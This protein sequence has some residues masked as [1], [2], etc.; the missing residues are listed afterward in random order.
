[1]PCPTDDPPPMAPPIGAGGE[2]VGTAGGQQCQNNQQQPNDDG[3]TFGGLHCEMKAPNG[4]AVT[5]QSLVSH[6]ADFSAP[7]SSA[8]AFP[9]LPPPPPP[10]HPFA[11][12]PSSSSSS[13]HQLHHLHHHHPYLPPIEFGPADCAYG[14]FGQLR[15]APLFLPAYNACSPAAFPSFSTT[16]SHHFAM[17]SNPTS[18]T[19]EEPFPGGKK[20]SKTEEKQHQQ[21][22]QQEKRISERR[23][24][25]TAAEGK[26]ERGQQPIGVNSCSRQRRQRTHFSSHQ[27]A[28]LESLFTR[29]KYPDVANRA[30]M[31]RAIGLAEQCV[32][33]WFKN[34]RAKWRKRER[35]AVFCDGNGTEMANFGANKANEAK[36]W[37]QQV[38]YQQQSQ[39]KS[40]WASL[41]VP[42][43]GLSAAAL[44][45]Q[46]PPAIGARY[47]DSLATHCTNL[48]MAQ[49]FCTTEE[50]RW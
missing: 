32:R 50:K 24:G 49:A 27:L 1:M 7:A 42:G 47:G 28:E 31:S 25:T 23:K 19:V 30:E 18:F 34:R 46:S 35:P 38:A 22:Q 5:H 39:E 6:L 9:L 40:V 29:N 14:G 10:L 4:V 26:R 20:Q 44:S 43:G 3:I 11:S 13:S 36:K 37:Q 16:I 33:V 21:K 8:L 15:A 17:Y 41:A 2:F 45:A 48:A 12:V